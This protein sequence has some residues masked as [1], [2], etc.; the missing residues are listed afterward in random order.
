MIALSLPQWLDDFLVALAHKSWGTQKR[1]AFYR[2]LA[3]YV[4][5]G[6]P[7]RDAILRLRRQMDL[8]GMGVLAA[9]DPDRIALTELG[10]RIANGETLAQALRDWAPRS[11]LA[12]ISAGESSG[13]L[14]QSLRSVLEGQGIVLRIFARILFESL[15]P[16]TMGFLLLYLIYTIGTKMIPPMEQ[17]APPSAWPMTARLMLPMAAI[18]SSPA[19]YV[20]IVLLIA[21]FIAAVLSLPRWSGPSRAIVENLP[22]WSVYR[23]MQGAQWMLGFSRLAAAG[24]PQVE[25]LGIQAEF[26]NAWLKA[27]LLDARQRMKNGKELGQALI[28]GGYGFPDRILADDISAF[29]GA[30]DFSRLLA[31]LGQAWIAETEG[32]VLGLVRMGGMVM[33]LG[34]NMVFLVAVI[35]MS[36]MQGVMTAAH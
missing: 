5:N 32:K 11:E 35:G 22:P 36:Q 4:E 29:S 7:L 19:T 16:V 3:V 33:T 18:A 9:F 10:D 34:V 28:E 14:P 31:D 25:A 21:G 12:V 23:R 27:R 24:I 30:A 2:R 26:A 15:E 20:C 13:M 17:L 1:G 6:I 8:R